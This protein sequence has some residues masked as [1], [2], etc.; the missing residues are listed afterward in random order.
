MKPRRGLLR[1]PKV[2]PDNRI[3]EKRGVVA[4]L[5]ATSKRYRSFPFVSLTLWIDPA[6]VTNQLAIFYRWNDGEPVGYISW[7]LLAPD[8]EHKWINDPEFVLHTSEWNE[9]GTLWIMDFLA[10]PGYCEDIIEYVGE[11]MFKEYS[12]AYSLRRRPDN[13]I[14]KICCWRRRERASARQVAA[15]L[16]TP[17][18]SANTR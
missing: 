5:M 4:H 6:L 2:L 3:M 1:E 12:H 13:S 7:A 18:L 11:N 17:A 9:G 14:R 15:V 10:L 8:V 16:H